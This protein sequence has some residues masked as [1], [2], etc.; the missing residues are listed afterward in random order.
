MLTNTRAHQHYSLVQDRR[1]SREWP[2][3]RQLLP[4]PGPPPSH[5]L[6]LAPKTAYGQLMPDLEPWHHH[7][8]RIGTVPIRGRPWFRRA[9]D[10][11]MTYFKPTF[12]FHPTWIAADSPP[13]PSAQQ[14]AAKRHCCSRRCRGSGCRGLGTFHLESFAILAS[15]ESGQCWSRKENPDPTS[16]LTL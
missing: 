1:L 5:K 10:N 4:P 7:D 2:D 11:A 12:W 15:T 16:R 6:A 14:S 9:Q 13:D 3:A 8:M